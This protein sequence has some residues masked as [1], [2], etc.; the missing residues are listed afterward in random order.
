MT[1]RRLVSTL[2][3]IYMRRPLGQRSLRRENS[4]LGKLIESVAQFAFKREHSPKR[5]NAEY[6]RLLWYTPRFR[7]S[8]LQGG[9]GF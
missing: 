3:S 6:A 5:S 7:P 8:K 4:Q 2:A 9:N 1:G